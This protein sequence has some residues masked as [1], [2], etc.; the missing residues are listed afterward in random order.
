MNQTIKELM[1]HASRK[2]APAD[3]SVADVEGVLR[4]EIRKLV[5]NY[6]L[7]QRNKLDLFEL[8]QESIDDVLPK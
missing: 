5:G 2:T 3:F 4:E 1:K 7:F 8:I 6:N